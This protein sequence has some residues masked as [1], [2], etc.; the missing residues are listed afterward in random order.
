MYIELIVLY[1]HPKIA[2][3]F[4]LSRLGLKEKFLPNRITQSPITLIL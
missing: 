1:V 4:D 3:M 2:T